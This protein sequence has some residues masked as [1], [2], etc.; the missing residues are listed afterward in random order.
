MAVPGGE[1]SGDLKPLAVNRRRRIATYELRIANDTPGPLIGFTYAVHDPSYRGNINWSTVTV[2]PHSSIATP[3]E[4]P[5]PRRGRLPRV[6]T[7]LHAGGARLTLDAPPMPRSAKWRRIAASTLV[8][9]AG[10]AAGAYAFARPHVDALVAPAEVTAGRAFSIVYALAPST[11]NGRY[12]VTRADGKTV[13]SGVLPRDRA[14]FSIAL[15]RAAKP[16]AYEVTISGSNALGRAQRSARVL[17]LAPARKPRNFGLASNPQVALE[18]ETVAGGNPIVVSYPRGVAA[19]SVK[20]IDQD[21]TERA[22]AL[23]GNR[24]SSILIAPNVP[25]AQDFRVV[26]DLRRGTNVAENELP[27]RIVPG[28]VNEKADPRALAAAKT[29]GTSD[30]ASDDASAP[31]GGASEKPIAVGKAPVRSG[32]PIFVHVLHQAPQMQIALLDDHG[33]E[34]QRVDVARGEDRLQLTAPTVDAPTKMLVVAS[35]ARGNSQDSIIEPVT[36]HPR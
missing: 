16:A 10:M 6:V 28:S 11:T 2:P 5:L 35:F 25:V 34:L 24:G 30:G 15:P 27:V 21:G 8:L 13:S 33:Q 14:S 4:L 9:V 32:Q 29:P 20:L 1:V 23:V 7:E 22:N 31:A 12:S 26:V 17:A 36:I 3:V 18:N 19:G